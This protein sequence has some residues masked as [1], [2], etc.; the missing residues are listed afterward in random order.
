MSAEACVVSNTDDEVVVQLR[1]PKGH[2]FLQCEELIQ[3][4]LNEAGKVATQKCLED[5]DADGSPIIVAGTTLTAKR[6]KVSKKYQ[7]PYGEMVVA[8]YAYQSS[9]GGTVEIPLEGSARIIA[10]ST[11]RFAR[12]VSFKYAANNAGDAA[13]DLW[14][15]HRLEVSRCYI[16]DISAAVAT[17]LGAKDPYWDYAKTGNEPLPVQVGAVAI[18]LD[19]TCM[20]FCEGGY[21]Q[22]MV[23]TIAFFDAAGERLHTI[24]VAAAPEFGKATF[25]A[26]MD[27]E[28]ARVKRRFGHARYVG[29]SDGA[30]DYLAWLKKHTT[31]QVLDFWHV[32]EYI[33]AAAAAVHRPKAERQEWIDAACH[34]LK[35]EHGAAGEIL[36]EFE[37]ARGKKMGKQT[38]A[39]LGAAITYFENGLGRMNYASYRKSHLP[40]G[41]GVTEAACKTIVKQ[42]MCG[43][44]MK[45]K[46][47]GADDVLTLRAVARTDGGWETFWR[48]IEKFGVSKA[49]K[50]NADA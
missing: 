43:S 45:W 33:N 23:G 26:R 37:G 22:A 11:P 17:Q 42:R 7:T 28:I 13:G 20:L 3:D 5:F 44:G 9:Q 12:M 35:H 40:I 1:V 4:A 24:Y 19:G 46:H 14:E 49:E 30:S 10:S 21:R 32:T 8:R 6:E 18:G 16:Q 47:S 38:R 34:R 41:S 29:I 48:R 31:T 2:S 50:L 39:A 25:L 36:A 27:A 15:S